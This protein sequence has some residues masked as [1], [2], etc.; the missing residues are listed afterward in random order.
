MHVFIAFWIQYRIQRFFSGVHACVNGANAI[1]KWINALRASAPFTH[2]W[3][4]EE[5]RLILMILPRESF[6]YLEYKTDFQA[7]FQS[8][9]IV[10]SC[11]WSPYCLYWLYKKVHRVV[12]FIT[13]WLISTRA[14][15]FP[16]MSHDMRTLSYFLPPLITLSGTPTI[17]MSKT[18][19]ATRAEET[20]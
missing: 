19:L 3:T 20:A 14:V 1:T 11:R 10:V 4:P 2:A 13:K 5:N 9:T 7:W 18:V 12:S 8:N 17:T 16:E 15:P 6:P